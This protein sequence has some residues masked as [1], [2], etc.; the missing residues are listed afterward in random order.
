MSNVT[1]AILARPW[2]AIGGLL[3]VGAI[4]VVLGLGTPGA[5]LIGLAGML[6][7]YVSGRNTLA[8]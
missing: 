7:M 1:N 4:L 2:A 8:R 3:A 5:A 6:V